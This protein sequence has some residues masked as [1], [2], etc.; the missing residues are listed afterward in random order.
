[1]SALAVWLH[2]LAVVVWIGGVLHQSLVLLP[3]ARRG[4]PEVFI[5][6]A[7]RA[8]PVAWAGVAVAVL[9]GF[10]NATRLGSLA[11]VLE[12]GAALLLS[13]KFVLVIAAVAVAGQRDFAQLPRAH[14]LL[15]R[16]EDPAP[17]LAAIAWL[18]R[19]VLA[20]A[21]AIMYLGLSLSRMSR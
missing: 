10:F 21:A 3:P 9:T 2:L 14:T 12:S 1:M 6:T 20:L 17:A 5:A 7:R 18:D 16:G 4:H 15:T 11:A 19:A 8:R 13:G